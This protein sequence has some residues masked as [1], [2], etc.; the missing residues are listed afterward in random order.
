MEIALH[1]PDRTRCR[2]AAGGF[3]HG[4]RERSYNP[5]NRWSYFEARNLPDLPPLLKRSFNSVISISWSIALHISYTVRAAT[6]APVKAS[7]STPV[8]PVDLTAAVMATPLL[9][10]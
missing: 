3:Q 2:D 7:I 10:N 5:A 4:S 1:L 9:Q 8:D 6:A